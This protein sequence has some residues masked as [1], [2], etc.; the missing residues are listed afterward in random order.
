MALFSNSDGWTRVSTEGDLTLWVQAVPGSSHE[1]VR[2]T[3]ATRATPTAFMDALWGKLEDRSLNPEVVKRDILEDGAL[4]R[5]YWDVVRAPP[6][7]DRDYVMQA[8]R[9]LDEKSGVYSH[10]FETVRDERKPERP[11]MVRMTVKGSCVVTPR[12][13]GGSDV[14]YEVFTDVAGSIPA[15][16]ARGPGRKSALQFI[17]EVKRR[18]EQ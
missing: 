16:L 10:A 1:R 12:E 7:S 17:R 4:Q 9:S 13:G 5:R 15:F 2:V 18:A 8:S 3:T 6:V 11:D 14:V